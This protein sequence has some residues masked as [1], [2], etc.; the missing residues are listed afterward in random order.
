M[1]AA[2]K[3]PD[4]REVAWAPHPG[5]QTAFL[6]CP[7]EDIF[8]G[9]ARGPGKTDALLA[10]WLIHAD[11]YGG[12]AKGIILRH[13]Y[14]Q[15]EEIIERTRALFPKFGGL[16]HGTSKTWRFANGARYVIRYLEVDAD[17]DNYH[18]HQ[19]THMAV[20]EITN[21]ASLK[22]LD[23]IRACLRSVA[24]VPTEFLAAGNP[25]GAGHNLIKFRYIDQAP[26]M[27]PFR[28]CALCDTAYL[29]QAPACDCPAGPDGRRAYVDRVFIPATMDDNPTLRDDPQYWRQVVAS[30]GGD[31]ALL[32]A[33]RYGE[34]D[35]TAGGMFDDLWR[36]CAPEIESF[37]IPP[38]WYVDRSFDWG[39]SRPYACLWFAESNGE[40]VRLRDGT[41]RAWPRGTLFVIGE[42]YGW[43]GKP[44]EGLRLSNV[45]I[46]RRVLKTEKALG[47]E[48]R[49]KPGPADN[50][51]FNVDNDGKC[52]AKEMADIGVRWLPANKGP[53]SRPNGWSR[54][55][56]LLAAN[57]E[58]V[59]DVKRVR[60][61]KPMEEPGLFVF[62]DRCPQTIRTVKSIPRDKKKPDDV[63]TKAE[64]HIADALR[65]RALAAKHSMRQANGGWE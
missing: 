24:G 20:D 11:R 38:G 14:P 62:A 65:Y 28:A 46:A 57:T 18:G 59:D 35:I 5:P 23:K 27:T 21:F 7:V 63:D 13:S 3:L 10:R 61:S 33:W 56:T 55:R 53:G 19:F 8:F 17:A 39:D 40:E 9:G 2:L 45:E 26:P 15:L 6:Y 50:N 47:L 34:W 37:D 22:G 41:V 48:G 29:H 12:D 60:R 16:Y 30:A 1:S 43:N 32:R 36:V 4:G 52:I 51:I 54:L 58:L 31:D 49:T 25:G 44:N 64:D 42:E